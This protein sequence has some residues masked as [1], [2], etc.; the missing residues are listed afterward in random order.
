MPAGRGQGKKHAD[1]ND[2]PRRRANKRRGHGTYENDRP[3]VVGTVGRQ[4]GQAR[5]RVVARTDG[6][7]LRKHVE[8]FTRPGT[9]VCTDEWRVYN[10]VSST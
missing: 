7:T 3:P 2:P 4:S 1:P 9:R 10:N 8:R 5:L 6:E